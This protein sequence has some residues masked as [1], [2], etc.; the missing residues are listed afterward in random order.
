MANTIFLA[1]H[2]AAVAPH[3]WDGTDR[4][5]PLTP[6]GRTQAS[7]LAAT[8][9]QEGLSHVAASPWVRCLETAAAV[10]ELTG[11][12][13][14]VDERLGYDHPDL[15]AWVA[16]AI[17]G[18]SRAVLAVSHGDLVPAFLRAAGALPLP[19]PLGTG[20]VFQVPVKDGRLGP[21]RLVVGGGATIG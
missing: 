18:R 2:G 15:A 1:R 14:D 11:T 16:E 17:T 19:L 21:A 4:D 5:R 12:R 6:V 10:A 9:R 3:V 7:M 13:V 8:L 20:G